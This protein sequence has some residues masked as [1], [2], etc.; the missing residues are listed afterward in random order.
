MHASDISW[1][2]VGQKGWTATGSAR[3]IGRWRHVRTAQGLCSRALREERGLIL[4]SGL[5]ELPALLRRAG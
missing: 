4:V 2:A 5:P 1:V 3:R